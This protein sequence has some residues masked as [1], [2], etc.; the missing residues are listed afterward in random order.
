MG[1]LLYTV[2]SFL[3]A[4]TARKILVGAGLGLIS[5]TFILTLLQ[6]YID[7]S[8]SYLSSSPLSLIGI[9]GYDV[10]ISVIMGSILTRGGMMAMSVSIS[11]L[12]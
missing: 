8:V 5:S 7:S 3:L 1:K 12:N 6:S 10:F 9:G 11:K 4:S 2:F